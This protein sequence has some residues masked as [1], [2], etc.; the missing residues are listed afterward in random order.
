ML[1]RLAVSDRRD[2]LYVA[3]ARELLLAAGWAID[4]DGA[5]VRVGVRRC[6]DRAGQVH[7][8]GV[9]PE[10][11]R[12]LERIADRLD[13]KPHQT[14]EV[15]RREGR[16][17]RSIVGDLLSVLQAPELEGCPELAEL[18]RLRA[19]VVL[20]EAGRMGGGPVLVACGGAADGGQGPSAP[21]PDV[22]AVPAEGGHPPAAAAGGGGTAST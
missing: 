21:G 5:L 17:L 6:V 7:I 4:Q 1:H 9:D 8:A 16:P 12:A 3:C 10:P 22:A 11:S 15:E 2:P 19:L 13:G 18:V 20:S 14:L